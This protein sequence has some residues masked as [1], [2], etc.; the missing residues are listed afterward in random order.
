MVL[1]LVT[2]GNEMVGLFV[3]LPANGPMSANRSVSL[4]EDDS[5]NDA[6]RQGYDRPG[7]PRA[8]HPQTLPS[9]PYRS[10]LRTGDLVPNGTEN[11]RSAWAAGPP[12]NAVQGMSPALGVPENRPGARI[13]TQPLCGSRVG[14]WKLAS[15]LIPTL[16]L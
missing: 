2:E 3:A 11:C 15:A 6:D 10:I 16:A 8:D 9:A 4:E 14:R 5:D 7:T 12:R 13:A 1:P